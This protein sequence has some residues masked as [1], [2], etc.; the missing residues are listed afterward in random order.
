MV[1]LHSGLT[2]FTLAIASAV[3]GPWCNILPGRNQLPR[4]HPNDDPAPSALP[5]GSGNST[6]CRIRPILSVRDIRACKNKKSIRA[7]MGTS[8]KMRSVHRR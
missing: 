8:R 4:F 7:W 2:L 1:V 3:L 5:A 6:A